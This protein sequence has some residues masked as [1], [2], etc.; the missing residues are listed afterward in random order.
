[1]TS[2]KV[3]QGNCIRRGFLSPRG[4]GEGGAATCN[5][6]RNSVCARSLMP[7]IYDFR[8]RVAVVTG[9]AQGI[10][11]A[12]AARL[13]HGGATVWLWA[14]DAALAHATAAEFK[15]IGPAFAASVDVTDLEAV[16]AAAKAVDG[17]RI[18]ILVNNAGISGPN[19]PTWEY[20]PQD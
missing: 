1:K 8:D 16:E 18:D 15:A 14:R 7:M 12:I 5:C 9:G 10:G 13:L 19:I 6:P 2:L 20:P 4:R 17:G 3:R 11:R